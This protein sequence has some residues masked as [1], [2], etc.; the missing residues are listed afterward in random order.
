MAKS[1]DFLFE[2]RAQK[3]QAHVEATCQSNSDNR[4]AVKA[5]KIPT[6]KS[7]TLLSGE[8]VLSSDRSNPKT[9]SYEKQLFYPAKC[10]FAGGGAGVDWR[11][12]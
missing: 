10:R 8:E 9:D 1:P 2:V 4:K 5:P 12:G 11:P 3:A 7:Q 6:C